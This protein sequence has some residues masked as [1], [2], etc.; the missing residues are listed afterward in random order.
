VWY[1]EPIT[2]LERDT[3]FVAQANAFLDAALGKADVLCSLEE[4]AQTL[5]VN[6]AALASVQLRA[7]VSI[8]R[9]VQP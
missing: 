5:R 7:W 8:E 4:G 6:L 1:D 9:K 3:L 2:P